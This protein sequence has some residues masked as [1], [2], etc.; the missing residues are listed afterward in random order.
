MGNK[1]IHIRKRYRILIVLILFVQILFIVTRFNVFTTYI[2]F[3][4]RIF[5][6]DQAEIDEICVQSGLTGEVYYFS[7]SQELDHACQ[8]LNNLRY[9][10]WYPDVSVPMGGWQYRVVIV[11]EDGGRS[12]HFGSDYIK[13][14]GVIFQLRN[15][16]MQDLLQYVS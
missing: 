11:G 1:T 2:P 6:I 15:E 14:N 5:L 4:G 10:Y 9:A 16:G 3:S 12:F 8:L 13:V 7:E